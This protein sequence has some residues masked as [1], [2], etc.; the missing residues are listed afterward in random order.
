MNNTLERIIFSLKLHNLPYLN[1]FICFNILKK[2][3]FSCY[4]KCNTR[5]FMEKIYISVRKRIFQCFFLSFPCFEWK[6]KKNKKYI[7]FS[8]RFIFFSQNCINYPVSSVSWRTNILSKKDHLH[9]SSEKRNIC[10]FTKRVS[11]H[12]KSEF[13]DDFLLFRCFHKKNKQKHWILPL[14][15]FF[16]KKIINDVFFN[17]FRSING[18]LNKTPFYKYY[19]C[20]LNKKENSA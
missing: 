16:L 13:F 15:T 9:F 14:Y 3:F 12:R 18:I 11:F 17:V 6:W 8:W 1:L 2:I 10:H 5:H 19:I 4:I 20:N 7:N